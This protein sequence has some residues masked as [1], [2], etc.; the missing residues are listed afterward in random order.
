MWLGATVETKLQLKVERSAEEFHCRPALCFFSFF[1]FFVVGG[2]LKVTARLLSP[3]FTHRRSQT[4]FPP[5]NSTKRGL[6]HPVEGKKKFWN[7]SGPEMCS[8]F[9]WK[10]TFCRLQRTG[11][12]SSSA[13]GSFCRNTFFLKIRTTSAAV[14]SLP[15]W[16]RELKF[17]PHLVAAYFPLLRQ[18]VNGIHHPRFFVVFFCWCLKRTH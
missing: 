15:L 18:R 8:A 17:F 7:P 3:F 16:C 1:F 11:L 13:F 6:K 9:D 2:S 4:H 12:C 14:L 10:H 5:Q